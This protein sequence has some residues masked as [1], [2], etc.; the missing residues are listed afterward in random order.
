MFKS[1]VSKETL[2]S[3]VEEEISKLETEWGEDLYKTTQG[4]AKRLI[5]ALEFSQKIQARRVFNRWIDNDANIEAE[6]E[7]YNTKEEILS[8]SCTSSAIERKD[9]LLS[10]L[11][12]VGLTNSDSLP[13][14]EDT[15]KFI[16]LTDFPKKHTQQPFKETER[17][18]EL[19][20]E[21]SKKKG[22]CGD[23]E[24][25]FNKKHLQGVEQVAKEIQPCEKPKYVPPPPI[26]HTG[27]NLE[28]SKQ[29]RQYLVWFLGTVIIAL[30]LLLIYK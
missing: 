25:S 3:K 28:T 7:I 20:K 8:H 21:V 27:N 5:E 18:R 29:E 24:E 16:Y 6:E 26:V 9:K 22:V 15:Y 14:D 19:L 4:D 30:V 12:I 11:G 17:Y 2:Q 10:I 13:I 1:E 23:T